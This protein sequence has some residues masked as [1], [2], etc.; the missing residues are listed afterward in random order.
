[1]EAIARSTHQASLTSQI[2][3]IRTAYK[4]KQLSEDTYL[5]IL[6][7]LWKLALD[8]RNQSNLYCSSRTQMAEAANETV[9]TAIA[10]IEQLLQDKEHILYP[11]DR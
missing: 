6:E 9:S 5:E 7:A 4:M 11:I 10:D 8:P 1:M 2:K 3:I